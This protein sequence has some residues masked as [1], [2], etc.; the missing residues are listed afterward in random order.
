MK[1]NASLE[2]YHNFE[3][4]DDFGGVAEWHKEKNYVFAR[5]EM[6]NSQSS[7]LEIE[8]LPQNST[9]LKIFARRENLER[10]RDA[11]EIFYNQERI[12]PLNLPPFIPVSVKHFQFYAKFQGTIQY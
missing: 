7:G 6:V 3:I 8:G 5:V 10:L 1:F 9:I 12:Y 4:K 11:D 2:L